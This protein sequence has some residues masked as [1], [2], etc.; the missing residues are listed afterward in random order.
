MDGHINCFQCKKYGKLIRFST[1][2]EFLHILYEFQTD[3]YMKVMLDFYEVM[4]NV[5]NGLQG[6]LPVASS[7]RAVCGSLALQDFVRRAK[8]GEAAKPTV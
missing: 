5:W 2:C 3:E 1:L 7:G 6:R 8:Q 4:K